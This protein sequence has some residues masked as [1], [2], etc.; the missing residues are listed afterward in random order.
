MCGGRG[1]RQFRHC[2]IACYQVGAAIRTG[3]GSGGSARSA[4]AAAAHW[5]GC[6]RAHGPVARVVQLHHPPLRAHGEDEALLIKGGGGQPRGL[7][8]RLATVDAQVPQPHLRRV[9]GW[10][11]GWCW[12]GLKGAAGRPRH[13][14]KRIGGW[15]REWASAGV[16]RGVCGRGWRF[17]RPRRWPTPGRPTCLSSAADRKTSDLG[18]MDSVVTRPVWPR[19]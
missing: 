17:R 7:Q 2:T 8:Q 9:W 4:H 1:Q 11:G 6:E 16:G 18:D 13:A 3:Y 12:G 15:G 19:K 5:E 10:V 14:L